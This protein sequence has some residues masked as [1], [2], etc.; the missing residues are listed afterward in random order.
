MWFLNANLLSKV[1]PVVL[2]VI[3]T[4][5]SFIVKS[6]NKDLEAQRD[7]ES[8]DEEDTS[9]EVEIS[10]KDETVEVE[11]EDSAEST[12]VELNDDSE[13][14]AVD[15]VVE[16]VEETSVVSTP[17]TQIKG[18]PPKAL[19]ALKTANVLTV[20]QALE[21]SDE[22]LLALN[23]IGAKSIEKIRVFNI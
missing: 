2:L 11:I 14:V 20:E 18:L 9:T 23:G 22:D 21:M 1:V 19:S 3:I 7:A 16:E 10:D 17:I 6:I 8:R 12:E 4:C 13:E 5:I 15:Y